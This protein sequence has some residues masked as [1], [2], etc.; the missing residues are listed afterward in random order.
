M[1]ETDDKNSPRG[2]RQEK[3][4]PQSCWVSSSSPLLWIPA[5]I[6]SAQ[7]FVRHMREECVVITLR[8]YFKMVPLLDV[9]WTHNLAAIAP[10]CLQTQSSKIYGKINTENERDSYTLLRERQGITWTLTT[11]LSGCE[12]TLEAAIWAVNLYICLVLS[13]NSGGFIPGTMLCP[14]AKLQVKGTKSNEEDTAWVTATTDII[15][16]KEKKLEGSLILFICFIRQCA[17][18][19][20]VIF[21]LFTGKSRSEIDWGLAG[22]SLSLKIMSLCSV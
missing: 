2:N 8:H 3:K 1:G 18:S 14:A 19:H 9:F 12:C 20:F 11:L 21:L 4:T 15:L 6:F 17:C 7:L 10:K 13:W 16:R 22:C 5:G